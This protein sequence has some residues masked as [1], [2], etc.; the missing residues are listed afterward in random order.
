MDSS[1][2]VEPSG[3]RN[4]AVGLRYAL[5]LEN[6]FDTVQ[7][8][9]YGCCKGARDTSAYTVDD[10]VVAL[11]RVESVGGELVDAEVQGSK[12]NAQD[13][14]GWVT[15]KEGSEALCA[16]DVGGSFVYRPEGVCVVVVLHSLLDDVKGGHQ[17][18]G[19][20]G[21][22][23]TT[24]AGN[25]RVLLVGDD[26][27][28]YVVDVRGIFIRWLVKIRCCFVIIVSVISCMG[29]GAGAG[30]EALAQDVVAQGCFRG[31]ENQVVDGMCR[32]CAKN[33]GRHPPPEG[34]G[35]LGGADLGEGGYYTVGGLDFERLHPGLD[36][37]DREHNS[38]FHHTRKGAR[39]Q[40]RH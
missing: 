27:V 12:G 7:G 20:D 2:L 16:V 11:V 37:V 19:R 23:N 10:W 29:R 32:S 3:G 39:Q 33:N 38:V 36:R 25:Q 40:L 18:I 1:L 6:G 21:R 14:R 24:D 8:R 28:R 13:Q 4:Q 15:D 30:P 26:E 17:G 34:K 35:A 22:R 5:C 9:G 31:F